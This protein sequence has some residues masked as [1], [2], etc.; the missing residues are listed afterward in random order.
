M[1]VGV[2]GRVGA[3]HLLRAV[4]GTL[5]S[6]A[7]AQSCQDISVSRVMIWEATYSTGWTDNVPDY[8]MRSRYAHDMHHYMFLS[9]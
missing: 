4:S 8:T 3:L 1:C 9:N 5:K 7:S 6:L 2:S